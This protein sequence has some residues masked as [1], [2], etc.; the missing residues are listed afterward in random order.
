MKGRFD[1]ISRQSAKKGV[2]SIIE[3]RGFLRTRLYGFS[4]NS[5]RNGAKM[6]KYK[7]ELTAIDN[8]TGE[9]IQ[10]P[11]N[12][13]VQTS[14]QRQKVK[15]II[16]E[17]F[18]FK[19]Y[20][21][22][23]TGGFFWS[24]YDVGMDY[25]PDVSDEMLAKIIYLLT[26]LD[27][28][29]NTLVIRDSMTEPLRPMVKKD[30][31]RLIKLQKRQFTKFW[32]DLMASGIITEDK[33]G[34]L[35]V[36]DKHFKRGKLLKNDKKGM[37]AIKIYS[38]CVQYLYENVDVRSH[39]Y[40]AYLY[41]LIPFINLKYNVL[42]LNP[43]ETDKSKI[44]WLTAKEMCGLLGLQE[45]NEKRLI[46]TLFKLMFVDKNGDR[47]SV[48]TMIQNIRNDEVCRFITIDPQFYAGYIS[49]EDILSIMS[50]FKIQKNS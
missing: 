8:V 33:E 34:R 45:Q 7:N 24:I 6:M 42:C 9:V 1:H 38:H 23:K 41:R 10:L 12:C 29:N 36:C 35:I 21:A 20:T 4:A 39:K 19:N 16:D 15:Q 47:L 18:W 27:Y 50:E 46:D 44:Q 26:Y 32:D 11:A 17:R 14:E 40:L 22:D 25:Y 43:L 28:D 3:N 31:Q 48:I 30:V 49:Q 37:A 2:H 5:V 13:T